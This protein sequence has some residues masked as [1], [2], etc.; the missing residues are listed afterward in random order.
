MTPQE[1]LVS[2]LL[3][4]L[5]GS[6]LV[7]AARA[8]GRK[9]P[10]FAALL[11][12]LGTLAAALFL[13]PAVV[14]Q[15]AVTLHVPWIG[16]FGAE[17]YLRADALSLFV[18]VVM[19]AVAA[20]A[21]MYSFGYYEGRQRSAPFYALCMLFLCG[22]V[23]TAVAAETILFYLFWELMLVPSYALVTFW[24]KGLYTSQSGLK[25]FIYTHVGAVAMLAGILW[26]YTA[27]GVTEIHRIK[28]A[29]AGFPPETLY[30]LAGLF[31]F[32]FLVKMAI[33]PF[34]AWLP[35]T[36]EDAPLAVT[37]LISG[38]MSCAGIYGMIRFPFTL[39]P[40]EIV[41]RFQTLLLVLAVIT[42]L[43]GGLMALTSKRLRRIL[44][45]SSI[46]QMGYVLFGIISANALGVGGAIFH[47]LNHA[48]IK[49]LLFMAIGAVITRTG[50]Q[51]TT[52]LGGL[53]ARMPVTAWGAAVGALAIAGA[54]PLSG[55]QS[56]W[57]LFAG[58]FGTPHRLLSLLALAAGVLTA[59]YALL[60]IR[61]VFFGPLGAGAAGATESPRWVLA[62]MLAAMAVIV[63][64]GVA[65][66]PV[67][68]WVNAA[69]QT[70]GIV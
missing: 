39:F 23:G 12:A 50:Q 6:L 61:R 58:G 15:G 55:F 64:A 57:M 2:L 25:Y 45:Y 4:P 49:V 67:L 13:M 54:P 63:A 11:T 59:A 14:R 46:S 47:L 40:R 28:E 33:F 69:L 5:A 19:C 37:L 52:D 56:E 43:Y 51:K 8:L 24:G 29:I 42:Q 70:V 66:G 30:A 41:L 16:L 18:V 65:P 20:L 1:L 48:M 32:G 36:Y 44:A 68:T 60:L 7:L 31:L 35:G 27:T 34:H 17:F 26:I 21:V 9:A 53:A 38:A 22:M 62:P 3:I 10:G